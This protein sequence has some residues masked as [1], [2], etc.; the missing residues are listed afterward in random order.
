[1]AVIIRENEMIRQGTKSLFEATSD[2]LPSNPARV[3]R[4]H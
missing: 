2:R 3:S 4:D 1:M